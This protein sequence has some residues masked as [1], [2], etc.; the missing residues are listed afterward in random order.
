MEAEV[1]AKLPWLGDCASSTQ[2]RP[3]LSQL[4]VRLDGEEVPSEGEL[5]DPHLA[6][7]GRV[8][9]AFDP[10]LLYGIIEEKA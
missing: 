7:R 5:F 2:R 3:S 4:P 6:D 9:L 10:M 8:L 1:K